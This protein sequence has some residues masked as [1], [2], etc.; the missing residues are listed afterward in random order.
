MC[1]LLRILCEC[2]S[3][4]IDL[5][6]RWFTKEWRAL[7]PRPVEIRTLHRHALLFRIVVIAC[8]CSP[9]SHA[10]Q[11]KLELWVELLTPDMA[12]RVLLLLVIRGHFV[13]SEPND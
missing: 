1:I 5:E 2:L 6:D 3:V 13:C 4:V 8:A 10:P 12:K 9:T 7:D 11:G